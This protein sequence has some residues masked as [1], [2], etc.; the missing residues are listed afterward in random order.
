MSVGVVVVIYCTIH[1]L[2][3]YFQDLSLPGDF[4]ELTLQWWVGLSLIAWLVYVAILYD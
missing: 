4:M 1:F 2:V 3:L